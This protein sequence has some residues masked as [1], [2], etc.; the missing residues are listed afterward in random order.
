MKTR[1][2]FERH[3]EMMRWVDWGF[4][5]LNGSWE[6]IMRIFHIFSTWNY[7]LWMARHGEFDSVRDYWKSH[8][9][10]RVKRSLFCAR[11]HLYSISSS[12]CV[13]NLALL[14]SQRWRDD[15]LERNREEKWV[16][17]DAKVSSFF[18]ATNKL[19]FLIDAQIFFFR[20]HARGERDF[21][22]CSIIQLFPDINFLT[23]DSNERYKNW[24]RLHGV[25]KVDSFMLYYHHNGDRWIA[26][27]D[28]ETEK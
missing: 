26:W 25:K 21:D 20:Q 24:K 19:R 5:L 10:M 2:G 14:A 12:F 8:W 23:I 9:E 13:S 4:S 6:K 1:K 27:I 18:L 22:N 3:H 11:C 15:M 7:C 28:C 16:E 17:N